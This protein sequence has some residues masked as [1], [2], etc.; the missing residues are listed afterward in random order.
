METITVTI[1]NGQVKIETKGFKG[2]AC[3]IATK[4]IEAA[5]GGAESETLTPEFYQKPI[6]NKLKVGGR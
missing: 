6:E 3:Q 2:S 4:G 5:L 1:H